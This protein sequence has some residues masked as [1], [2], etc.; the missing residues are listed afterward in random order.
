M[1][2]LKKE[3]NISKNFLI[4]L[5]I[6]NFLIV[7]L[8][9]SYAAFVTKQLQENVAVLVTTGNGIDILSTS[10]TNNKITV[11]GNSKQELDI[12]LSNSTSITKYYNLLHKK[13]P[14]GVMIYETNSDGSS[15]G[16]I[17][18]LGTKEVLVTI[19]NNTN[20]AVTIEF[21][22]QASNEIIIDKDMGYSFINKDKNY[23]HS[24]ANSPIIT[25]M[26]AIPV[27]YE[28]SS[29][30]TGVWKKA[31]I[32]NKNDIKNIWYDYDNG[33]WAN[34][35]LVSDEN[36]SMYEKSQVGTVIEDTDILAYFVW[37]PSFRYKIINYNNKIVYEK[38]IDVIFEN[39]S[40]K[41]GTVT[42]VDYLTNEGNNHLYSEKCYDEANG[43]IYENLSTYSHP[44]FNNN[45]KG[46][47][48][49]KFQSSSNGQKII[50]NAPSFTTSLTKALENSRNFELIDN[51]YGIISTGTNLNGDG[52]ITNDTNSLDTHLL[53]NMEWG[54][55]TILANSLYGKSGNDMYFT[56][57][58]YS[59]KRIYINANDLGDYTGCSSNYSKIS[60]SFMTSTT[61]SC[62]KYN[63]LTNYT[64][65]SNGITYPVGPVGPGASTTGTI[66]G[67]YDMAGANQEMV[68]SLMLDKTN[69]NPL[70]WSNDYL[71]IYS[72]NSF[73]GTINDSS[74]I[75][76]LYRYKLGDG[77]R[78]HYRTFNDNGLWYSGY[79]KQSNTSGYLIRGGDY[80]SSEGASIFS[81]DIVSLDTVSA[82]RVAI[83]Y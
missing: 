41:Q 36:R 19:L 65:I 40:E 79:L 54:A 22:C 32:E 51:S 57:D 9:Y 83:S 53:T 44:A 30:T 72:S 5:L 80:K 23:D 43:R 10:L 34:I 69:T 4:L 16:M 60:K 27:Y 81:S 77:I 8:Y 70:S 62:I 20:E 52:T 63:D 46:F 48:I 50:P 25:D 73:V 14:T 21:Y 2:V 67:V 58:N 71:D 15:K 35:V 33:R 37:I 75:N 64:H 68:A 82:Y 74:N 59:F 55:V 18:G 26:K 45:S 24:G 31:D 76:N 7:G 11:S 56:D 12:E 49:S 61:A 78:E 38:D 13:V 3:I 47:W 28:A 42:C 39:G 6:I 29:D 17:D 1:N 66:Y